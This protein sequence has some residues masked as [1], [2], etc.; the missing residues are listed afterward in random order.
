VPADRHK[1]DD[2]SR[3]RLLCELRQAEREVK[4]GL[5]VEYDSA[6]FTARLFAIFRGEWPK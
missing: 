3:E 4:A 2:E 1:L 5:S 6:A